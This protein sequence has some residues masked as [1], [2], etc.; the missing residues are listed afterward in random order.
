M[1]DVD[2]L[3]VGA[4]P[5][6]VAAAVMAASLRLRTIVVERDQVGGRLRHIGALENVPGGW[7]SGRALA[8]ALRTDLKRIQADGRC[9]LI[10]GAA[11]AVRATDERAELVLDDGRVITAGT[12]VAAT[13]V[14]AMAPA[15]AAWLLA[16]ADFAPPMLWRTP[17]AELGDSPF[18]LGADRPL[19]TWLRVHPNTATDLHVLCPPG[20]DY[21]TAEVTDDPRVQ[22]LQVARVEVTALPADRGW[23]IAAEDRDGRVSAYTAT[24]MMNNLGSRP[25]ALQGLRQ[26]ED[27]YCPPDV[28]HLRIR[29]AGDLRSARCQRIVTA[30]GSGAEAVLAAYYRGRAGGS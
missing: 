29:A 20:D 14:S 17:P 19:G 7:S 21:K 23:V 11:T 4:G 16:E 25:A 10:G 18:V 15:D 13:G 28:Q 9:E 5:A 27:G 1:S 6:G 2:I 30:Q 24:S 22:L 8:D 12:V 26:D 3:I